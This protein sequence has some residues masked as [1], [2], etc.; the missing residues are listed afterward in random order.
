MFCANVHT[1]GTADTDQG[2]LGTYAIRRESF[3]FNVPPS[4]EPKHAA[5]LMCAGA[6]IFGALFTNGV[7]A[8]HNVG[9]VGVGGLGSLAIEMATKM[10][11]RVVAFSGSDSKRDE[12]LSLGA[13]EFCVVPRGSSSSGSAVSV[14]RKVDFLLVTGSGMP[15][16]DV[17]L[18]V[19]ERQGTV[20]AITVAEGTMNVPY[21][22][23]LV[24]GLR[25]VGSVVASRWVQ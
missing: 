1:F 9:V 25:F 4:L 12:A 14:E 13:V 18:G 16:W 23:F 10:G 11:C 21:M 22:Q 6:T 20:C 7:N 5:P 19:M 2:S 24:N 15:D 17:Y 3:L 8:T